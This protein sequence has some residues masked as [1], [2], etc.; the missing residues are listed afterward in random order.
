MA[1]QV[2]A[3][4]GVH[5]SRARPTRGQPHKTC[6]NRR[7]SERCLK[8]REPASAAMPHLASSAICG[9]FVRRLAGGR[10]MSK[11]ADGQTCPP[12][13]DCRGFAGRDP[14]PEPAPKA[15]RVLPAVKL[16]SGGRRMPPNPETPP[17]FASARDLGDPSTLL[18]LQARFAQDDKVPDRLAGSPRP[19]RQST[20]PPRPREPRACASH[21]THN[22]I[23]ARG[24]VLDHLAA[25]HALH[26][27]QSVV[28]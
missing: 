26:S 14:M 2:R 17:P 3:P 24:T 21:R 20:R 15:Q 27:S 16:A 5:R 12:A 4:A 28:A 10:T 7:W 22:R 11:R 18:A 25:L 13:L 19:G 23:V 1:R 9:G 8:F 6:T